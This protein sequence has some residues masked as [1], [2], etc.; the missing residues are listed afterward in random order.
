MR[1]AGVAG[2]PNGNDGAPQQDGGQKSG[3]AFPKNPSRS[4]R[5]ELTSSSPQVWGVGS[6]LQN[7]RLRCARRARGD[8]PPLGRQ[9]RAL[10]SDSPRRCREAGE[11]P[12]GCGCFQR[13]LGPPQPGGLCQRRPG[14]CLLVVL[15][16]DLGTARAASGLTDHDSRG[17]GSLRGAEIPTSATEG[18]CGPLRNDHKAGAWVGRRG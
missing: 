14:I 2:V 15:S 7:P 18:T 5:E 6:P 17:R 9:L 11:A 13:F 12:S 16:D 10:S 3:P 4:R 1:V 8:A